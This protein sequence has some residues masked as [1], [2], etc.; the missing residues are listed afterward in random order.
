MHNVEIVKP[1]DFIPAGMPPD[2]AES[3]KQA[4]KDRLKRKILSKKPKQSR[5]QQAIELSLDVLAKN[6]SSMY[7]V[8]M[9]ETA[10]RHDDGIL[11][12]LNLIE[13]A[14]DELG[15]MRSKG[16]GTLDDCMADLAR[17][18]AI[19]NAINKAC[20]NQDGSV[21]RHAR[22]CSTYVDVLMH[23]IEVAEDDQEVAA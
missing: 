15:R 1:S 9:A 21:G 23:V 20:G 11:D 16:Y 14:Q 3:A 13:I 10:K 22:S 2:A 19:N 12:S 4:T 8:M 17:I 5:Q 18:G 6:F 7:S